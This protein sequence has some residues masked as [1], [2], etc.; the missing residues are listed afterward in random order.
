M[1]PADR[2]G[3][4][5]PMAG[6]Q[7]ESGRHLGSSRKMVSRSQRAVYRRNASIP[8]GPGRPAHSEAP[9]KSKEEVCVTRVPPATASR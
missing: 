8:M 7:G 2:V 3:G 4:V 9:K 6:F 1:N 5:G